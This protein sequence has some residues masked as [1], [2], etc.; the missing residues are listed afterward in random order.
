MTD[1]PREMASTVDGSGARVE[2]H[3]MKCGARM[4]LAAY[5]IETCQA[6]GADNQ[7]EL[8]RAAFRECMAE[9]GRQLRKEHDDA[10]FAKLFPVRVVDKLPDGVDF[11]LVPDPLPT[12]ISVDELGR[13]SA[14]AK[15][16]ETED[17][18]TNS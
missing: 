1:Q 7:D 8:R 15:T 9:R 6:C 12:D 11:A 2:I 18:G 13:R 3:C 10:T 14:I 16:K 17:D 5:V 4:T